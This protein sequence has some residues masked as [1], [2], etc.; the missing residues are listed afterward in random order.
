[1]NSVTLDLEDKIMSLKIQT[2]EYDK[3]PGQDK[4]KNVEHYNKIIKERD[5]CAIQ[6]EKYKEMVTSIDKHSKT[7]VNKKDIIDDKLLTILINNIYE[8]K[9]NIETPNIKLDELV[10][11]YSQ[12]TDTKSQLDLYFQSKTM[13]IIKL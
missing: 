13:E 3:L 5:D 4:I 2:E 10:K 1:M 7:N 8:I 12:L 11:L 6:L 9:V